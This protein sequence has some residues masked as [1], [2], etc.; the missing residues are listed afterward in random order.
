MVQRQLKAVHQLDVSAVLFADEG[1]Q[2]RTRP[3]LLGL[4]PAYTKSEHWQ[5]RIILYLPGPMFRDVPDDD[6]E[7]VERHRHSGGH[8]AVCHL[9]RKLFSGN[10]NLIVS[11]R[12]LL[13]WQ[14]IASLDTETGS[15]G[16]QARV[17]LHMGPFQ[18]HHTCW[19]AWADRRTSGSS[20]TWHPCPECGPWTDASPRWTL[21]CCC[22]VGTWISE[23][24]RSPQSSLAVTMEPAIT[25]GSPEH[26]LFLITVRILINIS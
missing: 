16:I 22:R 20:P 5:M 8:P 2:H 18:P 12:E 10:I 6:D 15:L 3:P 11:T 25:A 19:D 1:P 23:S 21:P 26:L 4:S 7:R 13:V 9:L 24:L 14:I 17:G